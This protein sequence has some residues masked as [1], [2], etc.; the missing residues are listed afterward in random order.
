MAALSVRWWGSGLPPTWV[1]SAESCGRSLGIW[2][3]RIPFPRSLGLAH[4]LP[5]R[6]NQLLLHTPVL[7][8]NSCA[9]ALLNVGVQKEQVQGITCPGGSPVE[10][11]HAESPASTVSLAALQ[12]LIGLTNLVPGVPH[13]SCGLP[14]S[15]CHLQRQASCRRQPD[16]HVRQRCEGVERPRPCI[17]TLIWMQLEETSQKPCGSCYPRIIPS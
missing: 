10:G 7:H 6:K 1:H 13:T 5:G 12:V 9:L 15:L 3:V 4:Y 11:L 14:G 17:A 8:P 2:R 16:L